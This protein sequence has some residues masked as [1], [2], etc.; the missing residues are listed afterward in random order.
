MSIPRCH[1]G[2]GRNPVDEKI[3]AQRGKILVLSATRNCLY[4]WI[5]ACA[6]M[7]KFTRIAKL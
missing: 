7:T 5:P 1:S 6:G 2:A 3:L 4:G